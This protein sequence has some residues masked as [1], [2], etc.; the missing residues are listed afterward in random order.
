LHEQTFD[1]CCDSLKYYV[2]QVLGGFF[3][4][5]WEGKLELRKFGNVPVMTV[6]QKHRFS[7]SFSDFITRYT[8]VSSTNMRTETAAD[9]DTADA[10]GKMK[11]YAREN[12]LNQKIVQELIEKVVVTDP[13]HVE[14]VWKFSDK[15]RK[16]IGV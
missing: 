6:L 12:Q 15:V 13:E 3:C 5:N 8:A 4:I 1:E 14:I 2:G 7:S 9:D 16:F 11:R 10:L